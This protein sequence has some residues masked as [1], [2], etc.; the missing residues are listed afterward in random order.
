MMYVFKD[1][2]LTCCI[3]RSCANIDLQRCNSVPIQLCAPVFE[4]KCKEVPEDVCETTI[5]VGIKMK[6]NPKMSTY[7][8]LNLD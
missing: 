2:L 7:L 4:V 1:C 6:A 8:L 5:Q 3:F